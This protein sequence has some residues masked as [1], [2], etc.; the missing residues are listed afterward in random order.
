MHGVAAMGAAPD[1][2]ALADFEQLIALKRRQ[3]R[4]GGQTD[5]FETPWT[6]AL[7][8]DLYQAGDATFVGALFCL[9]IDGK[10]AAA[11]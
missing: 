1:A 2:A 3:Y 8:R 6:L 11:Q 4:D 5:I 10:L 9:R 7:L